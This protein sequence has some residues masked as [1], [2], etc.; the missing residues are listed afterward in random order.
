MYKKEGRNLL[1][2]QIPYWLID[3]DENI[4]YCSLLNACLAANKVLPATR[5]HFMGNVVKVSFA[6]LPPLPELYL[7]KLYSWPGE[8]RIGE[9]FHRIC[10]RKVFESIRVVM[11]AR[12][13]LFK[14]EKN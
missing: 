1:A 11:E 8:M 14:E 3:K 4:E 9:N 2:S 5:Y 12:G 13:Y 6:Y 7:W 10:D